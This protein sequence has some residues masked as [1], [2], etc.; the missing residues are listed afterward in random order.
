MSIPIAYVLGLLVLASAH[1]W[2]LVLPGSGSLSTALL[3]ALLLLVPSLV[4]SIAL[5]VRDQRASSRLWRILVHLAEGLLPVVY[6]LLLGPG[7]W[8]DL[9]DRW[10]GNSQFLGSLLALLPLIFA[11]TLRLVAESIAQGVSS[12]AGL[13]RQRFAMMLL[14]SAP[15][16]LLAAGSDA[17]V[18][19]PWVQGWILGTSPGI[20]VATLGFVLLLGLLMPLVFRWL[21]GLRS[22][23]EPLG[24]ELR[25]AAASLGFPSGRVLQL[26]SGYRT[27]N[28]LMLG[29]LPWPRYVVLSD[30]LLSALGYDVNALK[31]VVAHEVGHAQAGH[32]GMLIL[33]F[34]VVP[35]LLANA[36]PWIDVDSISAIWFAVPGLLVAVAIWRLVRAVGHRFEH[37]ADVLSAIALGGAEPCIRALQH[38]G[39]I[40][41][42]DPERSSLL[43]PSER[44]RVALLQQFATDAAFRARFALRGLRLRRALVALLVVA[45]ALAFGCW[46]ALAPLER[47]KRLFHEG[48]LAE[49]RASVERIGGD[50]PLGSW[51]GWQLFRDDL[52]AAAT[53]APAGGDWR[54]LAPRIA[55]PAWQRGV[56]VLVAQGP[57]AARAW[58]AL[59][60]GE[61]ATDP[62]RASVL[63]YC[64]AAQQNDL[65]RMERIAAHVRSLG[66]PQ[67]LVPVFGKAAPR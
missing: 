10:S 12:A 48:R 47:A 39:R 24:Q 20:T 29:P 56:E 42:Q 52:A 67:E 37:E 54:Q 60:L 35:L 8:L 23:G 51:Q 1:D 21:F 64:E 5:R 65:D 63:L 53:L 55:T 58:I 13:R 59:S 11:E 57:A 44:K 19:A 25:Q 32:P 41:Q 33:L 26:D 62:V 17:L 34:L 50:V 43:H 31:G 2:Y 49:A 6:G 4:S 15:W 38:V 9:A 7:T 36:S 66:V 27:V 22:I 3:F 18:G 45:T 16:L 40:L 46:Y 28:A 30:G 61:G 14:F